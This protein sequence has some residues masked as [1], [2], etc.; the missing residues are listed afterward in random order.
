LG[1]VSSQSSFYM[2]ETGHERDRTS[3]SP[4]QFHSSNAKGNFTQRGNKMKWLI[5][6]FAIIVMIG[7]TESAAD[8]E[9]R[10]TR[11]VTFTKVDDSFVWVKLLARATSEIGEALVSDEFVAPTVIAVNGVPEE[12]TIQEAAPLPTEVE[13]VDGSLTSDTSAVD[14]VEAGDSAA[15]GDGDGGGDGGGGDGGGGDGGD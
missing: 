3:T 15:S 4:E 5:T 14:A 9:R 12:V 8:R 1:K 7:C 6:V 10:H 11:T 2:N 13:G